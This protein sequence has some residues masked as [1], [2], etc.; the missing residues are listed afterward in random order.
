MSDTISR[1]LTLDVFCAD[2]DQYRPVRDSIAR[3]RAGCRQMFAVLGLAQAAGAKLKEHA[4][5]VRVTPDGKASKLACAAVL[6][7]AR[8][9]KGE[10][11]RGQGQ[12]Y[13]VHIGVG[14]C[15][16]MRQYFLT[17]L[18]PDALSFVWD[19]ARR[20]VWTRW[21][22]KDPEFTR[23]GRGWLVLQGARGLAWFRG[24][25]I[26]LPQATARPSLEKHSLRLSW[27]KTIGPVELHIGKLDPGRWYT[28]R[29]VL[30][31]TWPAGTVTLNER[32]GRLRVSV[33]YH[34]SID[35]EVLDVER[36]LRV[37]V[38]EAGDALALVGPDGETTYDRISLEDASGMLKRL[39]AQRSVWEGRRGAAG[40]PHRP[41]G[42]KKA[43]KATQKHLD[44]VTLLRE[45]YVTDCNHA[46]SRRLASRAVSWRCGM[47]EV[48]PSEIGGA[49]WAW[50]QFRQFAKY[51]LHEVGAALA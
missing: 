25:G 12:A 28:W 11:V 37:H 20:Q 36:V 48:T 47:V 24:V 26:E 7:G 49:T 3:Y 39:A 23:A 34:R 15:Y 16:E 44:R 46:W 32:D 40:S 30:D 43:W 5:G 18:Y 13:Q 21:T 33:S 50:D 8:I 9:E 38:T 10:K 51:K 27:D 41:W 1:S 35:P 4:E 19:S 2:E 29:Q 6:K 42:N 45:R 22:A 17:E 31:G 14:A